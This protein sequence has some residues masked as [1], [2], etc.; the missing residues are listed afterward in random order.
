MIL[1]MI[2]FFLR[3]KHCYFIVHCEKYIRIKGEEIRK[4]IL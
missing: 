1:E 4:L 2:V 3:A